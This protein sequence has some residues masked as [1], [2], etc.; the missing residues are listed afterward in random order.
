MTMRDEELLTRLRTLSRHA[1][2]SPG[3]LVGS[4]ETGAEEAARLLGLDEEALTPQ[5]RAVLLRL[6]E[7]ITGLRE[8]LSISL[9]RL[10]EAERQANEDSLAPVSNRRAFLRHLARAIGYVERYG[11]A[12]SLLYFDLN[13]LKS[14]NDNHGHAA[15]DAALIHVAHVLRAHTRSSDVVGRLGGDEYGVLLTH[16]DGAAA[17]QKATALADAVAARKLVWQ[18][19]VIPVRVAYG[20]HRLGAGE[21]PQEALAA[22]D[23]AMYAQ[24]RRDQ[25][26]PASQTTSP[27]R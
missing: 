27:S 9:T 22:A 26:A 19:G 15:G 25:G 14:I 20:A 2:H 3:D 8:Q 18:Q 1:G 23:R 13:D 24:K 17:A 7:E 16:A 12:S 10:A 5:V 21:D 6:I 4:A 11:A